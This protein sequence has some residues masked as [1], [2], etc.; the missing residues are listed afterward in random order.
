MDNN[1]I[2]LYCNVSVLII[3]IGMDKV[4][5]NVHQDRSMYLPVVAVRQA[6]F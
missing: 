1:G 6:I 3:H 2:L 4:V 5:F